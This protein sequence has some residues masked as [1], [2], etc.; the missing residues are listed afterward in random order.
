MMWINTV[1][2]VIVFFLSSLTLYGLGNR[3]A[4]FA[5]LMIGG[6]G[7]AV[8]CY[9]F[10]KQQPMTVAAGSLAVS[11]LMPTQVGI[12]P[13]IIGFIFFMLLLSLQLYLTLFAADARGRE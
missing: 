4:T 10:V 13:M 5:F 8:I 2:A 12:A 6:I 11:L 7:F 3:P 9:G 1:F